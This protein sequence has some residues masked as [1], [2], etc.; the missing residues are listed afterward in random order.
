MG[1]S[2]LIYWLV[3]FSCF[4]SLYIIH[5]CLVLYQNMILIFHIRYIFS[6]PI[7][8][9]CIPLIYFYF[10]RV[11]EEYTFKKTDIFHI[12]PFLLV[13]IY[14]IPMYSL[15]SEEKLNI[16]FNSGEAID[17]PLKIIVY[18]KINFLFFVFF[19]KL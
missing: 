5:S 4:I 2:F 7:F 16:L 11:A 8:F 9:L 1:I 6:K 12:V 10:R 17:T 13:L 14:F 19:F 18:L 3:F 15:S